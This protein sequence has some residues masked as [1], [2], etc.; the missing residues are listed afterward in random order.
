MYTRSNYDLDV[1]GGNMI[2]YFSNTLL[3]VFGSWL[4]AIMYVS[5][6]GEIVV[7]K[8]ALEEFLVI[9]IPVQLILTI[10]SIYRGLKKQDTV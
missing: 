7:N 10:W 5:I 1:A 4:L 2:T 6:R 3:S 8:N 9:F